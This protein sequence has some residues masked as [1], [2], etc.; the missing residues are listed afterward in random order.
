MKLEQILIELQTKTSEP[1]QYFMTFQLQFSLKTKGRVQFSFGWIQTQN[2]AHFLSVFLNKIKGKEEKQREKGNKDDTD[3]LF[4]SVAAPPLFAAPEL[5][6][7][8]AGH[9]GAASTPGK[10]GGS[11]S[12]HL[13]L[14]F[15]ALKK[16]TIDT[17]LYG[18]FCI[19]KW[20]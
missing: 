9:I 12:V 1:P 19:F 20:L 14:Y 13:N 8:G 17:N 15:G 11:G 16:F 6:S 18:S 4:A 3:F 2:T 5:R 10:K 7:P